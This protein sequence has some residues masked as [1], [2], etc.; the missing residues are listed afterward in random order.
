MLKS[1]DHAYGLE[2]LFSVFPDAV[3]IQT[4]RDP[5]EVLRSSSQ[6]ITALR[7]LFARPG[8]ED[9]IATR[10]ARVLA[11]AMD[12]FIRF[13]DAHPELADRF[14]D[15]NYPELVSDPLAAVRRIYREL[16]I[17][18]TDMAAERIR[19]LVSNRSRH[20]GHRTNR[21]MAELGFDEPAEMRR[22]SRY[23]L[24]FGVPCQPAGL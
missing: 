16:Q 1:P 7:A 2:E 23:S 24:R 14:I 17:P 12:R 19:H 5:L 15:V 18:L 6:L 8:D 21:T 3:I 4:H 22:F 11:E 20:R 10:E 9:Q 13:R